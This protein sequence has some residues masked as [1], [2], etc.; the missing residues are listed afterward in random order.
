M[1]STG[2]SQ[3]LRSWPA[4]LFFPALLAAQTANSP[5]LMRGVVLERDNAS[6]TGE[7]SIRAADNQVFRYRFDPKT[8][9]EIESQV[10]DVG[11]IRPGDKVEVLS[12]EGPASAL[13]YAR[14]VHLAEGP[15]V[16]QAARK[17]RPNRPSTW[18]FAPVS[19]LTFSGVVS[20]MNKE[21]IVLHTRGSGEQTILLRPDTHF[22]QDGD[23]VEDNVLQ[24]NMRVFVRAGR[25]LYDQVE[26]YQ[27]IWGQILVP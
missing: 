17:P 4:L 19:T 9:V 8:Y 24:P 27:I 1:V 16:V 22:L 11:H 10:S 25:N 20:R 13:R 12:D 23:S 21:R 2:G 7:F 6:P 18:P 5:A 15:P 3:V 14:T 26:A